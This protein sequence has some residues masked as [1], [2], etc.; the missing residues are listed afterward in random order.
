MITAPGASQRTRSSVA[1]YVAAAILALIGLADA[2]YLVVHHYTG[3]SVRCTVVQGC[4]EVLGSSY[5]TLGGV[6]V[7]ALGAA[8]YFTV[9]SLATLAACDYRGAARLMRVVVGA[10]FL[11]SLWLLYLQAFVIGHFCS[12]CLLSAA[13]TTALAVIVAN[14]W[15]R[16]R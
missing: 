1:P 11:F 3:R 10:M 9:F 12:Y 8:A 14:Q 13:L 15:A 4:D 16:N 2:I 5:A 6:P 7:A